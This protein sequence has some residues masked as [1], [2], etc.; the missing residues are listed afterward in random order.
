MKKLFAAKL[1]QDVTEE[2]VR[3]MFS[4][5]GTVRSISV[6]SDILPG[7]CR[8]FGFIEMA[9]HE[10]RAAQA[11]LDGTMVGGSDIDL[12]VHLEGPRT[13]GGRKRRWSDYPAPLAL[14]RLTFFLCTCGRPPF[15]KRDSADAPPLAPDL[16]PGCCPEPLRGFDF[17][18]ARTP[19]RS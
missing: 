15:D 13:A 10:A 9:G 16:L 1:P 17:A 18:P 6:A 2:S 3:A 12:R 7:K 4:K 14:R 8:G 19:L 11:A 5:F